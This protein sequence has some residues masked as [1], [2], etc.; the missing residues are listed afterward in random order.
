MNRE[1][2]SWNLTEWRFAGFCVSDLN[3]YVSFQNKICEKICG[4]QTGHRCNCRAFIPCTS[5]TI[6]SLQGEG[7]YRFGSEKIKEQN[8]DVLVIN[9]SLNIITL[10]Y[11]LADKNRKE[12]IF[13]ENQKLTNREL[14]IV[15]LMLSKTTRSEMSARLNITE[16]TVKWYIRKIY[17]KVSTVGKQILKK[18]RMDGNYQ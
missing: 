6:R 4:Q 10:I 15:K 13:F 18:V 7:S 9:D 1:N 3:G 11:P 5:R 2:S 16:N 14:E 17:K 8:Y 12:I